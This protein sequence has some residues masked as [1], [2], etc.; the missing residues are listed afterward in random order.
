MQVMTGARLKLAE[1][2]VCIPAA[3]IPGTVVSQELDQF[4]GVF[5]N[6]ATTGMGVD[7]PA[8]ISEKTVLLDGLGK[9]SVV[10]SNRCRGKR[11]RRT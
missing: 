10:I 3:R 7:K 8:E 2:M 4:L 1:F 6:D 9:I 11:K 5:K